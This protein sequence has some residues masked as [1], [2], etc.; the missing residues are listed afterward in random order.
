MEH[1]GYRPAH[2]SSPRPGKLLAPALAL[3]QLLQLSVGGAD[4]P[5]VEPPLPDAPAQGG[6]AP[7]QLVEAMTVLP[8]TLMPNNKVVA[9]CAGV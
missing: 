2:P 8:A 9:Q 6:G 5:Q 1:P 3:L 7:P 4:H